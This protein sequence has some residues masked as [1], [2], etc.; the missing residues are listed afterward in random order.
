MIADTIAE[1]H[2]LGIANH[3]NIT[4]AGVRIKSETQAG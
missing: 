4:C 1:L 3:I 2:I